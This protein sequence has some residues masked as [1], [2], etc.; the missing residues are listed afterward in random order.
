[1]HINIYKHIKCLKLIRADG[2]LAWLVQI[3][4]W[5]PKYTIKEEHMIRDLILGFDGEVMGGDV[6][7]S[8]WKKRLEDFFEINEVG[9]ENVSYWSSDEIDEIDYYDLLGWFRIDSPLAVSEGK[10][11]DSVLNRNIVS[12]KIH[13]IS[14]SIY[15]CWGGGFRYDLPA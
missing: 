6:R 5:T 15:W 14:A 4:N 7:E 10:I 2:E 13:D 11:G 3:I 8:Q 1:M 9:M 12:Q